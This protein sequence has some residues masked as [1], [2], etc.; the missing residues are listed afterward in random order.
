MKLLFMSGNLFVSGSFSNKSSSQ[1]GVSELEQF[2][3]ELI[4]CQG[5]Y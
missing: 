4:V 1:D 5:R 2:Y 3:L